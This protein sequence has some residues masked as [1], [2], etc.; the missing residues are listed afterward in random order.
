M[1][2][3]HLCIHRHTHIHTH[4]YIYVQV[5]ESQKTLKKI[6]NALPFNKYQANFEPKYLFYDYIVNLHLHIL[7]IK[8]NATNDVEIHAEQDSIFFFSYHR[9]QQKAILMRDK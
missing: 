1:Y 5:P 9:T 2:T 4:L 8:Y 7:K 3:I 6:R